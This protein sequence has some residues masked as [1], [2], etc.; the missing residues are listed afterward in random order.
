[1]TRDTLLERVSYMKDYHAVPD[2]L[3]EL[4][5]HRRKSQKNYSAGKDPRFASR[6]LD[7]ASPKGKGLDVFRTYVSF[8]IAASLSLTCMQQPSQSELLHMLKIMNYTPEQMEKYVHQPNGIEPDYV[9]AP[10]LQAAVFLLTHALDDVL[11]DKS[12]WRRKKRYEENPAL[13]KLQELTAYMEENNLLEFSDSVN[14]G[15]G[16]IEGLDELLEGLNGSGVTGVEELKKK[17][18]PNRYEAFVLHHA[19]YLLKR[20]SISVEMD[21]GI[22]LVNDRLEQINSKRDRKLR[23]IAK[24]PGK[25]TVVPFANPVSEPAQEELSDLLKSLHAGNS[26]MEQVDQ[27]LERKRASIPQEARA[28]IDKSDREFEKIARSFNKILENV[29]AMRDEITADE[30]KQMRFDFLPYVAEDAFRAILS[31]EDEIFKLEIGRYIWQDFMTQ[32]TISVPVLLFEDLEDEDEWNDIATEDNGKLALKVFDEDDLMEVRTDSSNGMEGVT[33]PLAAALSKYAGRTVWPNLFIRKSYIKLFKDAGFSDRRARDF[34]LVLAT[35]ASVDRCESAN[36]ELPYGKLY[37]FIE[38]ERAAEEKVE[39]NKEETQPQSADLKINELEQDLKQS[40][41]ANQTCRHEIGVLEREVERLKRLLEEKDRMAEKENVVV[42]DD[43]EEAVPVVQF[44]F[45][46]H[47]KLKVVVYGGF[48]VFHR[49]LLKL[50][51]D[52][53]VIEP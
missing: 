51:P 41:K 47:T 24:N 21:E 49:E 19:D 44:K 1:M 17:I 32:S 5:N 26:S 29:D 25:K 9:P 31:G 50:I 16:E 7:Y 48:E 35:L 52:V 12:E 42:E 43:A 36:F 45:P 37:D 38:E 13:K 18:R 14:N 46:Y 20:R 22:R 33:V 6:Y 11:S 2:E 53:R 8:S 23:R 15:T 3:Y 40:R 28:I 4:L 10:Q 27:F 34:A 39:E 30:E